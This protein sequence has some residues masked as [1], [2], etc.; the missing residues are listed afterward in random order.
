MCGSSVN[1]SLCILERCS[2]VY[3]CA[4]FLCVIQDRVGLCGLL[5]MWGRRVCGL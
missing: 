4:V 5:N 3:T 1:L 2:V